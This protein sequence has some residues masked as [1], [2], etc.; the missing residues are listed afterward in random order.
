[1]QMVAQTYPSAA[2]EKLNSIELSSRLGLKPLCEM[3]R[4]EVQRLGSKIFPERVRGIEI[5]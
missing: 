2:S 3:K 4:S 5:E 1:M